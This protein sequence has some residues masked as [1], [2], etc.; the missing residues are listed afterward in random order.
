MEIDSASRSAWLVLELLN[1][2]AN[3]DV[4]PLQPGCPQEQSMSGVFC[5]AAHSVL[6][7]LAEIVAHEPK[8]CALLNF[9]GWRVPSRLKTNRRSLTKQS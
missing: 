6:Q 1:K 9:G 7:C 3:Y 4:L 8:M 5:I 2:L